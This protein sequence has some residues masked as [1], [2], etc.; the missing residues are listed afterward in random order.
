MA[1]LSMDLDGLASLGSELNGARDRLGGALAAMRDVGAAPLGTD[2]LDR[3]CGEFQESWRHGLGRLGECVDAVRTGV[4]GTRATYAEAESAIA[5]AFAA[6][7]GGAA[8]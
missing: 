7:E 1:D 4:D 8:R 6:A 2:E 5:R 3:A